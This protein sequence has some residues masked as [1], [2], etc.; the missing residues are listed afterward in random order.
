MLQLTA[1]LVAALLAALPAA[2]AETLSLDPAKSKL[3]FLLGATGHDVEGVLALRQGSVT[4]DRATGDAGGEIVLDAAATTTGNESRDKKMHQEVLVSAKFPAIV[5]RPQKLE[6]RLA[7]SGKSQV[8][9]RGEVSLLG[10]GHALALPAAVEIDGSHLRAEATFKIPFVAWGL[11]DPSVFI[12]KVDKEVAVTLEIE[13]ELAAAPR[14]ARRK[15]AWEMNST[16][17]R[18]PAGRLRLAGP[19]RLGIRGERLPRAAAG[20]R[21]AR[22]APAGSDGRLPRPSR[23]P[24]PR[25]AGLRGGPA[26]GPRGGGRPASWRSRSNISTPLR[27]SSTT[28]RRW[29]TR[30]SAG[31]SACAHLRHGEAAAMLGALALDQPGLRA[32]LAGARQ[33]PR[34]RAARAA[35][36]VNECLGLYGHPRRPGARSPFR[37]ARRAAKPRCWRSRAGKTVTLIRLTLVL[38]ALAGGAAGPSCAELERLAAAWGHAY[39]IADDFKDLADGRRARPAN[40]CAATRSSA[41]PTCRWRSARSAAFGRLAEGLRQG[42]GAVARLGGRP[43]LE[44]LQQ[45]LE[46]EAA[47]VAERLQ[48]ARICA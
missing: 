21:A 27:C 4:F 15:N 35:R 24:F 22:A 47:V 40:R 37:R 10:V 26:P 14:G 25:P 38:P 39:Q 36:L 9:L 2:A 16:A 33:L 44:R 20:R 12:L 48:P 43:E 34:G 7:P 45:V 5:F 11:Q 29:T 42:A 8:V 41:G 13:G 32:A 18:R 17:T 1:G 31:A 28:C 23:Q 30:P 3:T 6:G 46:D 19:G